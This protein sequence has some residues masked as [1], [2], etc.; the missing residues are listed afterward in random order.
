MIFFS[1]SD[2]SGFANVSSQQRKSG[3]VLRIKS[4][5]KKHLS[6]SNHTEKTN[7]EY[8]NS[9][10]SEI[11]DCA[12]SLKTNC[13]HANSP[14]LLHQS[15]TAGGG[16]VNH[17]SQENILKE[18]ADI[19][20]KNEGNNRKNR[21]P[22]AIDDTVCNSVDTL[23]KRFQSD[24]WQHR[25]NGKLGLQQMNNERKV[26]SN[27]EGGISVVVTPLDNAGLLFQRVAQ[28]SR[29][30]LMGTISTLREHQQLNCL[31]FGEDYIPDPYPNDIS[32]GYCRENSPNDSLLPGATSVGKAIHHYENVYIEAVCSSNNVVKVANEEDRGDVKSSS[33]LSNSSGVGSHESSG[34]QNPISSMFREM[35]ITNSDLE[36][37]RV[38]D[39]LENDVRFQQLREE[40]RQSQRYGDKFGKNC[41]HFN[42]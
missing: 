32:K 14:I 8:R 34:T 42:S 40:Y 13:D 36:S 26:A 5:A 18:S 6:I 9:Q 21:S 24:S 35:Y 11:L 38:V 27:D 41:L 28:Y 1:R 30:N 7:W 31:T 33:P 16:L 20:K 2:G 29:D 23:L 25:D 37:P 15:S 4:V 22:S 12:D 10:T 39:T 17:F 19:S 3:V